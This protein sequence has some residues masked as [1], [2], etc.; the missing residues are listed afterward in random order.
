MMNYRLTTIILLFG[1]IATAFVRCQFMD[2]GRPAIATVS[3]GSKLGTPGPHTPHGRLPNLAME[4]TFDQRNARVL[5]RQDNGHVVSWDLSTR[6][7]QRLAT[8]DGLFAYCSKHQRLAVSGESHISIIDGDTGAASLTIQGSYRY[9]S[10]SDDCS[11]LALADDESN[12]VELWSLAGPARLA[13]FETTMPVRNGIV[14]SGSAG[15]VIAALGTYSKAQG[16]RTA[17]EVFRIDK[18][19]NLRVALVNE[20]PVIHGM[21]RMVALRGSPSVIVGSQQDAR[22][23]LSNIGLNDGA[24]MWKHR[25][26]ASYWVRAL[27]LSP[28]D[29]FLATG[30][31]NGWLRVWNPGTGEKLY[32]GTTGL[33][34]QS[35]A[36]SDN[37]RHL[38]AALWDSTIRIIEVDKLTASKTLRP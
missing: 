32:E 9:A 31:E 20:H 21:W 23:G 4:I 5:V 29:Q 30:D 16:H 8:T 13:T 22:S 14:L 38:A 24:M 10:W 26:F 6:K 18:D 15:H 25:G 3:F 34:I 2:G 35:L 37:G 36:F 1:L 27:A 33:V 17:L 7:P 12:A 19:T 28:D 11:R